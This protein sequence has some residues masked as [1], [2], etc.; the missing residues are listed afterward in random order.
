MPLASEILGFISVAAPFNACMHAWPWIAFTVFV[1][2]LIVTRIDDLMERSCWSLGECGKTPRKE[3]LLLPRSR[4]AWEWDGILYGPGCLATC[5]G[6]RRHPLRI[7]WQPQGEGHRGRLQ[8]R[9]YC[10]LWRRKQS[11]GE[12]RKH[13]SW[14]TEAAKPAL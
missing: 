10:L 14:V 6:C 4:E 9:R 5:N 8:I 3:L 12:D 1:G 11:E 7:T 13:K 2:G